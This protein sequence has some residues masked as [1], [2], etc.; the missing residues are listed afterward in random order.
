MRCFLL[1]PAICCLTIGVGKA[2]DVKPA[3]GGG[4]I[5][6]IFAASSSSADGSPKIDI[7]KKKP[8][9]IVSSAADVRLSK[10]RKALRFTFTAPDARRFAD[11][12]RKY[13][14]EFLI[15]QGNGKILEAMQ[16]SSPVTNGI[17]EF[18]YPDDAAVADYLKKR[19]RL[20]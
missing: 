10:D 12:T 3:D 1:I 14:N 20:K 19:F 9:L 16:V 18:T 4:P 17:L 5:F 2:A 8:L 6:Q 11:L 7:G 13:A 15:L